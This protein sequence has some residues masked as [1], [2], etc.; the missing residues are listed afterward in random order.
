MGLAMFSP[1][2]PKKELGKGS[3]LP[4][5][6]SSKRVRKQPHATLSST[7]APCQIRLTQIRKQAY[8]LASNNTVFEK[9][10]KLLLE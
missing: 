6:T 10:E 4:Q 3:F 7:A 2:G 8:Y 5:S 1:T 9:S